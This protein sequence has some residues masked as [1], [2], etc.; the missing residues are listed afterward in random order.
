LGI[1][2]GA[3]T[4]RGDLHEASIMAREAAP[5][6]REH[7]RLFWLFD[8]LALRA[9]LAGHCKDAARIAGYA[10]AVYRTFEHPREPIGQRAAERV[11]HLLRETLSAGDIAQL[12]LEGA[13]LTE[14]QAIALA[15]RT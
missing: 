13:Q 2:A 14:D 1:L 3:L 12:N 10:D 7:G 4:A 6:M 9:G 5:L 11:L 8:H 15:L